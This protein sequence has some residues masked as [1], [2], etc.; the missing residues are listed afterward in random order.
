MIELVRQKRI[1]FTKNTKTHDGPSKNVELF[2]DVFKNFCKGKY[3]VDKILNKINNDV[4]ILN[5]FIN[6]ILIIKEKL[7]K[8]NTETIFSNLLEE[9]TQYKNYIPF[10]RNGASI[11]KEILTT[12][13]LPIITKFLFELIIVKEMLN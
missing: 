7:E 6:E 1:R 8:I 3:S 10:L 2:Y 11:S 13:H 5:Y 12:K 4:D 9:N